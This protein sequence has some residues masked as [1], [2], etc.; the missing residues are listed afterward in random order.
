MRHVSILPSASCTDKSLMT[1]VSL[2]M[3]H[4]HEQHCCVGAQCVAAEAACMAELT[5]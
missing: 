2:R 3:K 4:C 5:C 1:A